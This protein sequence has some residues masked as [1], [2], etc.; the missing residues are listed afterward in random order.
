MKK[1]LVPIDF[2]E[3]SKHALREAAVLALRSGAAIDILHVNTAIAYIPP[4]PE[5]AVAGGY[6]MTEYYETAVAALYHVKQEIADLPGMNDLKIETR[7]EEGFLYSVIRRTVEEDNADLIVMGTKGATGLAEFFVGSNT[8]KVIRTAPCPV[9]AVPENSGKFDPNVVVLA[10]T[11]ANDQK[12]VFSAAA[13]WQRFYPFEIKV[14]YLNNPADLSDNTEIESDT[15]RLAVQA[16]LQKYTTYTSG[17]TFNE[18]AAILAFA[19][20]HR[21]DLIVMGTHQRK[22]LSHLLF[23]SLVE[24]AANHSKIPVLSVPLK[25]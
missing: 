18:E 6:D 20:E 25:K 23:G 9:L 5:Y 10:T 14:L 17:D 2:S 13:E 12:N 15:D 8:E 7:I 3:N 24:D 1:I 4:L 11:L 19:S 21:A 16:G 22:G